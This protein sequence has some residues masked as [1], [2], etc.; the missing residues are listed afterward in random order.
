MTLHYKNI[1]FFG[2]NFTGPVLILQKTRGI[3]I[4][5]VVHH[6]LLI[7]LPAW[8]IASPDAQAD[9]QITKIIMDQKVQLKCKIEV[10]SKLLKLDHTKLT[11]ALCL[12]KAYTMILPVESPQDSH[13]SIAEGINGSVMI[14]KQRGMNT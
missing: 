12:N 4:S 1:S 13:N 5:L 11:R 14:F 3:S 2:R 9:N 7:C 10:R 6:Y 8:L